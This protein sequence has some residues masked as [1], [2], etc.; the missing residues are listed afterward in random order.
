MKNWV[1]GRGL[2]IAKSNEK[3]S[4]TQKTPRDISKTAAEHIA[5]RE[6]TRMERKVQIIWNEEH[7]LGARGKGKAFCKHISPRA[8]NSCSLQE[9]HFAAV[10]TDHAPFPCTATGRGKPRSFLVFFLLE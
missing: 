5:L 4:A 7:S 8:E 1:M 10:L 6:R 9:E 3:G 2:P